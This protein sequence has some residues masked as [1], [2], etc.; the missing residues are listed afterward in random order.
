[1]CRPD[2]RGHRG[3]APPWLPDS[4]HVDAIF[5]RC[6]LGGSSGVA[7]HALRSYFFAHLLRPVVGGGSGV[8]DIELLAAAAL[9]DIGVSA[10]VVG[11][12]R[13]EVAGADLAAAHLRRAGLSE[14]RATAVWDAIALHT[15]PGLAD[16]KGPLVGLVRAGIL[17]DFGAHAEHISPQDAERIFDALPW[18]GAAAALARD[19]ARHVAGDPRRGPRYTFAGEIS[20]EMHQGSVTDFESEVAAGPWGP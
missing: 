1:M 17:C 8:D 20:R 9:H 11:A 10:G 3:L 7:H 15:S 2:A 4:T 14:T 12:D 18:E 13:F 16:R 5:D 19:V 6:A